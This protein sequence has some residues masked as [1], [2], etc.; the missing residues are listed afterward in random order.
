MDMEVRFR[1]ELE[2]LGLEPG[3][4]LVAV[5]GGG[6]SMALLD[7]LVRT[8]DTHRLDLTVAH[9]DHGIHSASSDVADRVREAAAAFD[10]PILSRSLGLGPDTT[11]TMARAK[12][13]EALEEMRQEADARYVLLGHHRDDQIETV[14]MRLLGGTGPAG[15]A[16]M[17]D[18]QGTLVRPL[19]PF[20][21]SE[22]VQHM[23]T[24][25][26]EWWDDPAN[27]DERHLRSW[28]RER[29]LPLIEQRVPRAGDQLVTVARLARE[30]RAAWDA[31]I[32]ALPGLDMRPEVDGSSVA[33]AG[34][35][36]YDSSLASSLVQAVAR[37]VGCP[38]GPVRAGRVL[39]LAR[40]GRSGAVLEVPDGWRIELAF[41][42]VRF[43]RPGSD[44]EAG[45][46]MTVGEER[47]GV[48]F[49]GPW[50]VSWQVEAAPE[51]QPREGA[52]AWFVPGIL[53]IRPVASGDRV[54]PIGG[55]GHR[56]VVR[57][58]QD[59]RVPRSRRQAWPVVEAG[60]SVVWVPGVCRSSELVPSAGTEAVCVD[61]RYR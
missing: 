1:A 5:S 15:L 57:C 45:E 3:N 4:A 52:R 30:D 55:S 40:R 8:T 24:T 33:A 43:I 51:I 12:R 54:R 42:R 60:G 58:L 7:L 23:L 61:V 16:A 6:D 2:R 47:T 53:T 44:E 21:H 27:R 46:P 17:A 29:L 19:L 13:Y 18:R 36:G 26:M 59:A 11:E 50:M 34:I 25:E 35:A 22:L 41:D 14:L 20:R 56:A 38:L 37:R 9:V 10:L 49:W 32:E 31:A 39:E 28:I 48:R